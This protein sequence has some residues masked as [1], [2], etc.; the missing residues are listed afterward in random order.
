[1]ERFTALIISLLITFSVGAVQADDHDE[2]GMPVGIV[3]SLE[4]HDPKAF[5]A[6][7]TKYWNSET[8]QKNPGYAIVRQIVSGGE[9]SASHT[10]AVVYP[11]YAAWDKS[12]AINANSEQLAIFAAETR[13]SVSFVSSSIFEFTGVAVGNGEVETGSAITMVYQL[14]VS[15][16]ET[17]ATALKRFY[18]AAPSE[19][20]SGLFQI[21][22]AGE[23]DVTHVL[24]ISANSMADLMGNLKKDQTGS[25]FESF[26]DAISSTRS[27]VGTFVT[28]DIAVFGN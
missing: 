28:A 18:K 7:M 11:S 26:I 22:G 2:T 1:M 19:N 23:S 8:G 4:V 6:S 16:P 13:E 25:A 24:S 15:D 12:N 9:S 5:I 27:V 10:V 21:R 17:Y 3:Y 20:L 14:S